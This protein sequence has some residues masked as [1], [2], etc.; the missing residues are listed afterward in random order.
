MVIKARTALAVPFLEKLSSQPV[1]LSAQPGMESS[2]IMKVA[3]SEIGRWPSRM[4]LGW[5]VSEPN[6]D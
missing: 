1:G 4:S 6:K 3:I 5:F 2:L